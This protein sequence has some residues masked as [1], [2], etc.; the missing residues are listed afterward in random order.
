M[1]SWAARIRA[2]VF[3]PS[4][5]IITTDDTLR[6]VDGIDTSGATGRWMPW[7]VLSRVTPTMVKVSIFSGLKPGCAN[8]LLDS[9][10]MRIR[11]PM[12]SAP[13]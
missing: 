11:R 7:L 4:V 8:V 13:G 1:R 9:T 10:G 5:S 6:K 3:A 2:C 12:G